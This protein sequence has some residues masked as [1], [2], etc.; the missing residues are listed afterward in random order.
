MKKTLKVATLFSGIGAPEWALKRLGIK[1]ESVLACDNGDVK[2]DDGVDINAE[3]KKIATMNSFAKEKEYVDKLYENNSRQT[4]FVKK[5]YLA[6]YPDFNEKNYF[7]DVTLLNGKPLFGKVDLLIGGSPCQSFSTVGFQMGLDDFRGNLFFEFV[8]LV[9]EIRPKVFIYENVSGIMS[10]KNQKNW[11]KMWAVMEKLGYKT[12][13]GILNAK[14]Y[15]IPQIRNRLFVVGFLNQSINLEKFK[16]KK[17]QLPGFMQS[18]LIESTQDGGFM[19]DK[20]GDLTFSK[21]PGIIDSK[22]FLTPAVNK[23]VMSVGTKG[24]HTHIET[25]KKIARTLLSTMGNHH[26]AGVDNYV[27]INGKLRSLSERE[28]LRL[29]GFTDD[30]KIVVSMPQAYKQAGNSMVVDVM[31]ALIKAIYKVSAFNSSS[32]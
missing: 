22:Y 9:D 14:D 18:F 16:P 7:L 12:W 25:D 4:N 24:W 2:L 31:M 17:R 10:K 32:K 26:R 1:Y 3:R 28:C 29:M 30:Y 8:R 6:N 19:F 20:N 27:T 15:G 11:E 21:I 5:S 13:K 23:Y